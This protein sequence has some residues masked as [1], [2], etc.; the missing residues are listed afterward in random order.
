MI[1]ENTTKAHSADVESS[2]AICRQSVDNISTV[3]FGLIGTIK[4]SLKL[5]INLAVESGS[6]RH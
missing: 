1:I 5:W 6:Q 4:V 2:A 3:G